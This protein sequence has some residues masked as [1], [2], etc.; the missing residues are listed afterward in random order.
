MSSNRSQ[1]TRFMAIFAGGTMLS[2]VLGFVRDGFLAHLDDAP[3]DMFLFAF[4]FPNMLR[5]M[6]GEG[7]VNA[8]FVPLFSRC[9]ETEGEEAFQRLVRACL[10]AFLLLFAILSA[11]GMMLVPIF[12]WILS[13]LDHFTDQS[14]QVTDMALTQEVTFW[15]MPYFLLIGAAVFAMGPLFVVKRYGAA[16]WS[17][18]ILNVAM[19]AVCLINMDYFPHPVWAL[20]AGTWLGGIGQVAVMFHAM[21]K[22]TGVWLPSFELGHPGVRK[23]FLLLIPVIL[24]QATGEVNKLVDSFFAVK[25]DAV[26]YLYFSNRLVQ[27]P[28]SIFGIAVAVSIL[29]TISAAGARNDRKEIRDTLVFG[30]RQSAFLV[31]PSLVG[32]LVLGEPL[33]RLMFVYSGG[34]FSADDA[35]HSANAMF[36][37][38]WGLLAFTWVKVAVQGF[39]AIHDTKSPVII[40]SA[41][42]A[43]NIVLIFIL[44]KPMGYQGL[45]LATTLSYAANFFG[46]YWM[47]GRRFGSLTS[48]AFLWS[49]AKIGVSASLMGAAALWTHQFLIGFYPE[50]SLHHQLITV[51]VPVGVA[52]L[53][54]PA[55][56]ILLGLEDARQ[57]WGVFR[58]RMPLKKR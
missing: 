21:K 25:L 28:L 8:A 2:R 7:A 42:M 34:G 3:R 46:L 40:A 32:L 35:H 15:L 11:I 47:L 6:L 13:Q 51:L 20:V 45:A 48:A 58:R 24:G 18:V 39:F 12:P 14:A 4:R 19:I 43:L 50:H 9:R 38:S 17:P 41:S 49:L 1:L 10:G 22:H 33:M 52:M 30:F 16:S 29:P 44:V 26:S 31:M 54:Y 53:A 37:L 55:F 57:F 5:D 36:Y 56:S 27:L 23:A